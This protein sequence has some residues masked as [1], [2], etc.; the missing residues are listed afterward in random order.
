MQMPRTFMGFHM[1][2]D[3]YGIATIK[4]AEALARLAPDVRILDMRDAQGAFGGPDRTWRVEGQATAMCV[5]EFLMSIHSE[6]TVLSTMFEAT[7]L[8]RGWTNLINTKAAAVVVP[9]RWNADVFRDNGVRVPIHVAPLGLDPREYYPLERERSGEPYTFLWSGTPDL[10]KGFDV[11]YRAFIRA[12]AGNG[13]A[14]L[15]MHFRQLPKGLR[16]IND[17]N[18][19]LV[20]G[21]KDLG[22]LRGLLQSSDCYVFPSRGEGWGMPPREAGATGLPVIATNYGGLA[23]DIDEWALPLAVAGLS[24]AEYGFPE[25]G[26]IGAWAEPDPDQLVELMRWCYAHRLAAAA[27]GRRAAAWLRE[28]LTWAESARTILEVMGCD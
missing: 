11:A 6:R 14:R 2:A 7:R 26:D 21:Q 8:P 12:F 22:T 28:H 4:T 27:C 24:T 1:P 23:E 25:W 17:D 3:G 18:V 16:G 13:D 20:T 15:I 9:C 10:R 5:P 19:I